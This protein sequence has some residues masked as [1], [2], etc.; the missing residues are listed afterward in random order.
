MAINYP[1]SPSVNDTYTDGDM[2][3]KWDGSSWEAVF[4]T[5]I[6]IPSQS[7]QAGEFLQTDGTTM[8]WEPAGGGYDVA[9]TSTGY[10][11]IP[12]GTDAQRPGSP[13]TGMLRYNSD[14]TQLEHYADGGWIGFAGS[15]PTITSISTK[16]SGN[17]MNGYGLSIHNTCTCIGGPPG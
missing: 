6:P 4:E 14:N 8:T 16:S 2:T 3:W 11:D 10:F 17:V 15:T 5:N 1:T 12:S 7:G 9:S 13:G